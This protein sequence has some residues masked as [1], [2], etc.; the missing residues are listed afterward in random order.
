MTDFWIFVVCHAE[1]LAE[2]LP[3]NWK[4]RT[5]KQR[6]NVSPKHRAPYHH[7]LRG[8]QTERLHR[9][10]AEMIVQS[11]WLN[12]DPQS[13]LVRWASLNTHRDTVKA[14]IDRQCI[15]ICEILMMCEWGNEFWVIPLVQFKCSSSFLHVESILWIY[16]GAIDMGWPLFGSNSIIFI[17]RS[18]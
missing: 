18:L 10:R 11:P 4:P 9:P 5:W 16:Y 15:T 3:P 13:K 14:F 8:I 7:S 2:S 1:T 17:S 6:R 12:G